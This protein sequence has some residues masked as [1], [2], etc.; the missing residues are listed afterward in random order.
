VSPSTS[1]RRNAR[2][3]AYFPPGYGGSPRFYRGL[4]V[5]VRPILKLIARRDWSGRDRVPARGPV[6][7][8][9]NHV[10]AF[11]PLIVAHYLFDTGR[12]PTIL[13]KESLFRVAFLGWVLRKTGQVPVHRG[14]A[15]A[16]SA[17]DAGQDALAGENCVLLYPEGTLTKDPDLW[18]MMG[19][20]GAARLALSSRAPV[21]PLAQWGAQAVL[22]PRRKVLR[23]IPRKTVH[24]SAGP[25]VELDDL[26][27]RT[28]SNGGPTTEDLKEATQRIMGTVTEL[29]AELRGEEPPSGTWDP[30]RGERI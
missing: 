18:P 10:T 26:R 7:I 29:L 23:I 30:R 21:I 12:P 13:A 3:P 24:V 20:T 17:L 27:E 25:P 1:S 19:K 22:P 5:V 15:S 16:R 6:I 9:A 2:K 4:G 14:T 11:D 8:V 28:T